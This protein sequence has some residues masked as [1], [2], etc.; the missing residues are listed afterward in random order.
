MGIKRV[1]REQAREVRAH[2]WTVTQGI[3][4]SLPSCFQTAK[5]RKLEMLQCNLS[6][7]QYYS[8]PCSGCLRSL[9]NRRPYAFAVPIG[10]ASSYHT[11]CRHLSVLFSFSSMP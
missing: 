9:H 1:T 4:Y 3:R 6:G 5:L 7:F 10:S 8:G 11:V 2:G